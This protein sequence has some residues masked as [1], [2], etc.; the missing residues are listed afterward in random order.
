ML[1]NLVFHDTIHRIMLYRN[2][3]KVIKHMHIDIL[4][5]TIT[6][7]IKRWYFALFLIKKLNKILN[8]KYLYIYYFCCVFYLN[9]KINVHLITVTDTKTL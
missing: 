1:L 8:K 2:I 9:Y 3:D 4:F 7:L 5:V 6:I